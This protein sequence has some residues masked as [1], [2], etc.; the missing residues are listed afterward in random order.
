MLSL[1]GSGRENQLKGR[2]FGSF[3]KIYSHLLVLN[4]FF[5][6]FFLINGQWNKLT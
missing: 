6:T 3:D 4:K 5:L 1:T 2:K